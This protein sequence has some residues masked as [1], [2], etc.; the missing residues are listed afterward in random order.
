ME[1]KVK[2][3]EF[4]L[5]EVNI[6]S[7]KSIGIN[8]LKDFNSYTLNDLMNLLDKKCFE[9]ITPILK[10][11]YLP[12]NLENLNLID[13]VILILRNNNI[14]NCRELFEVD[15][16]FLRHLFKNEKLSYLANI[17]ELFILYK[18]DFRRES[19]F[20]KEINLEIKNESTETFHKKWF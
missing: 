6:Q 20:K 17:E 13:N 5:S 9:E 4:N 8:F 7:L 2:I 3:E 12:E 16:K 11:N 14:N 15:H 1:L 18:C 10:Q 19:D